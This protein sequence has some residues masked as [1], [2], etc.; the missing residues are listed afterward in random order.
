MFSSIR[1]T[2][3]CRW[4]MSSILCRDRQGENPGQLGVSWRVS[5]CGLCLIIHALY[6]VSCYL[7]VLIKS[8]SFV[9]LQTDK[10]LNF[11]RVSFVQV[12]RPAEID[13]RRGWHVRKF[14]LCSFS[15]RWVN[16]C[17]ATQNA[18]A[19]TLRV[20]YRHGLFVVPS[21]RTVPSHFNYGK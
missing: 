11:I 6:I 19:C 18:I 21:C 16:W 20:S 1:Y 14:C 17:P 12:K 13:V 5:I 8:T 2:Y 3:T 10:L 15:Y 7:W 4:L 9:Y